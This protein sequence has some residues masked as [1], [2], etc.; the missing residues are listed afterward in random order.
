[1]LST[2][3]F[4]FIVVGAGSA[5]CVLA[6]R[7]SASGQHSVLLIEARG[8]DDVRPA[9]VDDTVYVRGQRED[10]DEW[11]ALGNAGW[12]YAD[13][14][15][16]FRRAEDNQRGSNDYHG[17][18]G[19]LRVVDPPDGHPLCEAFF[20]AAEAYG[21]ARNPDANGARQ[22]GFGYHQVLQRHEH[23]SS[24]AVGYLRPA[25]LRSNLTVL[26]GAQVTRVLLSGKRATG[27][28]F[29]HEGGRHSVYARVEVVLAA[30]AVHSPL[31]LQLSGLGPASHLQSAGIPVKA[32]IPGVGA[33]LQSH[34]EGRLVFR[35]TEKSMLSGVVRSAR[36]WRIRPR[37]DSWRRSAAR[38]GRTC[39]STWCSAVS[40]SRAIRCM[41]FPASPWW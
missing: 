26:T 1:M 28:D 32:D 12:G 19:P 6:D 13:V 20:K 39:R 31:L 15:P 5:G 14:L 8:D 21:Y 10:Y 27:V 11:R 37:R 41:T 24:T 38:R 30:G 22:G 25:R 18:G 2:A 17:A 7:L 40:T 33:N 4:D 16:Y 36:T 29:R 34:Y 9:P 35:C 3:E 23:L